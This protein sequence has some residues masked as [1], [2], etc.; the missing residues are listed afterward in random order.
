MKIKNVFANEVYSGLG[1]FEQNF[2]EF[3]NEYVDEVK[4]FVSEDQRLGRR[5]V[6]RKSLRRGVDGLKGLEFG[7][8]VVLRRRSSV[9]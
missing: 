8:D 4:A 2:E 3:F 5:S 7:V 6:G 9:F 1:H